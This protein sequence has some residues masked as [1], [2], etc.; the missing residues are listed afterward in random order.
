MAVFL[1]QPT[2]KSWPLVLGKMMEVELIQVM[3]ASIDGTEAIGTKPATILTDSEAPTG[4]GTQ[5]LSQ[6][7]AILWPSALVFLKAMSKFLI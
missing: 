6:K 1:Y 7:M 5:S 2:V 4:Q 3:P